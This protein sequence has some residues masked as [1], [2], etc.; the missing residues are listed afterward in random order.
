MAWAA[1]EHIDDAIDETKELLFP[2]DWRLWAKL[3]LIV[4]FT[5]GL[6]LPDSDDFSSFIEED[7]DRFNTDYPSEFSD[8]PPGPDLLNGME[9]PAMTGMMSHAFTGISP[10]FYGVI[11]LV[12]LLALVILIL[13]PIFEFVYYQSLLDKEVTIM[14]HLRTHFWKGMWLLAF[15]LVVLVVVVVLAFIVLTQIEAIAV[16]T[17]ITMILVSLPFL[18]IGALFLQFTDQ[19]I[20]LVML[21]HDLSLPAAWRTFYPVVK[22]E[23]KQFAVYAVLRF[24]LALAV[25]ILVLIASLVFLI[26]LIPLALLV[27]MGA[28]SNIV[29]ALGVL[30]LMLWFLAVLIFLRVPAQTYLRYYTILV[31]QDLS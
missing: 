3:A 19:F 24:I 8:Y 1:L 14:E 25:G 2:F 22:Q 29:L 11:L 15:R 31:Y 4:F 21:E 9:I 16:N 30:G 27:F 17:L 13:A 7:S 20:P 18:L 12:L 5:S 26:P 10:V 23:W 6:D 28:V